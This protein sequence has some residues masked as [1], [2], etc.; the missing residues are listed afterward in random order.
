MEYEARIR[1]IDPTLVVNTWRANDEGL[2]NDV[3]VVNEDTIFRFPKNEYGIRVLDNELR[4]MDLIRSHI[5]LAMPKPFYQN[6]DA[7]A[8]PYLSGMPL[9]RETVADLEETDRQAVADQLGRFLRTMHTFPLTDA[10]RTEIAATPAPCRYTDWIDIR[11]QAEEHV[12]PLLLPHQQDWMEGLFDD[13]LRDPATFDYVPSLIHGDLAPYHIL[14]DAPTHRLTG[15]IDFGV[16][17]LGD[18]A[19]DIGLLMCVYG[20]RFVTRLGRVYPEIDRLLPRSR[21]YAQ[22]SQLQ[23]VLVGIKT[24]QSFWFAAHLGGARDIGPTL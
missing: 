15:I 18:P 5:E 20:E 10:L 21:F 14:F 1:Q 12:R 19:I 22:A 17:G 7:I 11:R 4:V 24:G 16:A 3:V 9:S 13:M 6:K 8:Y 23:W 2:V